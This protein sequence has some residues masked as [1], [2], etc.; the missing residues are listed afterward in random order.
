MRRFNGALSEED[1]RRLAAR[2]TRTFAPDDPEVAP[3]DGTL[4]W[5]WDPLHRARSPQPFVEQIFAET[6]QAVTAPTLLVVGADS[7]FRLPGL[8]ARETHLREHRK[9]VIEGA[10]HLVH[11]DQPDVLATLIRDHLQ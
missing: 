11:H 10:G 5:T 9:V 7:P 4:V 8:E 3:G 1:A 6:L 2:T